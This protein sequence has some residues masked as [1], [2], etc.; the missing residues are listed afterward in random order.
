MGLMVNTTEESRSVVQGLYDAVNNSDPD[1]FNALLHPDLRVS[2]QPYFPGG[3]PTSTFDAL[4]GML[5]GLIP[6]LDITGLVLECLTAEGDTVFALA[7]TGLL[8]SEESILFCEEWTIKDG[9]AYRMRVFCYD[10]FPAVE[11]IKNLAKV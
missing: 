7:R 1:R 11:K 9:K 3:G 2:C 6:I 5:A 10:P 4:Q 8:D